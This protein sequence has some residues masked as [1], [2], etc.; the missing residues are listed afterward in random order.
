MTFPSLRAGGATPFLRVSAP[1]CEK[2]NGFARRR[3]D[4]EKEGEL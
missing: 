1:P 4:A 3:G 2:K